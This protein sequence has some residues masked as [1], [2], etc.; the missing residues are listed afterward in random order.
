MKDIIQR[1]HRSIVNMEISIR[2]G[3]VIERALR[4]C[5]MGGGPN[6]LGMGTFLLFST[7]ECVH[8]QTP[9]ESLVYQCHKYE[10][11]NRTWLNLNCQG[12]KAKPTVN[13]NIR[14]CEPTARV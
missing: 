12:N 3:L 8:T 7:K 4:T 13:A 6:H 9:S 14:R 5:L 11:A 1:S 2:M 10:V